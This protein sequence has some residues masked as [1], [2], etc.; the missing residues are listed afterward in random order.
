[1]SLSSRLARIEKH[2]ARSGDDW[3]EIP[4]T[5]YQRRARYVAFVHLIDA[6]CAKRSE[7]PPAELSP[8]EEAE[9]DREISELIQR[10]L[11]EASQ[12]P[13]R[14]RWENLGTPQARFFITRERYEEI[15]HEPI[16]EIEADL[17]VRFE[18]LREGV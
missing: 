12:K 5:E 11:Q 16:E 10:R 1:M 14:E 17:A 8:E 15:P 2:T 7:S 9:A 6:L 18:A 13:P 3:V 4:Y